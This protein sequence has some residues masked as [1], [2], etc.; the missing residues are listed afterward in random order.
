MPRVEISKNAGHV[1]LSMERSGNMCESNFITR[2]LVVKFDNCPIVDNYV[3]L[4]G[5]VLRPK[6]IEK[7][8]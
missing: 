1:I 7:L 8:I 6:E 3:D 2:G 4:F 5:K